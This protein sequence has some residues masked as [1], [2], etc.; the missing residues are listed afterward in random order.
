L[1]ITRY[2]NGVAVSEEELKNYTAV[3]D[4]FRQTVNRVR[5]RVDHTAGK[6]RKSVKRTF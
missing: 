6:R 5:A 3:I 1:I 4:M 2:V